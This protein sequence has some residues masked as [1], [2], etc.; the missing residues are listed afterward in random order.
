MYIPGRIRHKTTKLHQRMLSTDY[1]VSLRRRWTQNE[2]DALESVLSP[3]DSNLV[4]SHTQVATEREREVKT[5]ERERGRETDRE[6]ETDRQ[7]Q[8]ETERQ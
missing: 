2:V 8:T 4:H 5:L 7:R 1:F 3:S 6:T